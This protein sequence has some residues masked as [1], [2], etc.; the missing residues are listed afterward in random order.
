MGFLLLLF[1][2]L[3][4]LLG[5]P[6]P[7]ELIQLSFNLINENKWV[8]F[9]AAFLEGILVINLYFPGSLVILV[10]MAQV[11]G[12]P[13]DAATVVGLVSLGFLSA[14]C[15]NYFLG[16]FGWYRIFMWLGN[17]EVLAK[18]RERLRRHDWKFLLA[19]QVHPN[20]GAFAATNAGLLGMNIGRFLM[21]SSI[22][23]VVWCSIWGLFFY[24]VPVP[25]EVV[26][27]DLR[28]LFVGLAVW[29]IITLAFYLRGALRESRR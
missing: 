14:N 1:S 5:A 12:Q 18:N 11:G 2:T 16:K 23:I 13:V 28:L 9:V 7:Q 15:L 21:L 20:F 6:S 3:Y 17:D 19:S 8:I 25:I 26:A 22:A 10:G 27:G 24:F 4:Q 29:V